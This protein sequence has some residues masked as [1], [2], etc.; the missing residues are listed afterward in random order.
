ML[1]TRRAISGIYAAAH[2]ICN[3][4]PSGL[5]AHQIRHAKASHWLE[6]GMN[7]VQISFLLGH[8]NLHTTMVYLDITTEQES[9]ALATLEDEGQQNITKKWKVQSNSLA[10][11]LGVKV[12]A[13]K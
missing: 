3:E 13:N 1:K 5:H 12:I 7:I 10:A 8:A 4:V 2:G 9:K 6:D 11:F